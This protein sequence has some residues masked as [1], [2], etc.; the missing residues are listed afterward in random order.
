MDAKNSS[1]MK[2]LTALLEFEKV[3]TDAAEDVE[4]VTF[5]KY[6]VEYPLEFEKVTNK[7]LK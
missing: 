1:A 5:N 2:N 3:E 4:G 7:T 6:G